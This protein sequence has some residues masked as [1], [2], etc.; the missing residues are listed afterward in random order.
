MSRAQRLG[1]EKK[2]TKNGALSFPFPTPGF[3]SE[4]RQSRKSGIRRAA[5]SS[6]HGRQT[7]RERKS[8]IV[9]VTQA[10]LDAV[11]RM[12]PLRNLSPRS[13]FALVFI[14]NFSF[15]GLCLRAHVLC[16]FFIRFSSNRFFLQHYS[17]NTTMCCVAWRVGGI[18][19]PREFRGVPFAEE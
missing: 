10:E 2:K 3:P 11:C 18:T 17:N 5:R 1:R 12:T 6:L 14:F 19:L 15:D 8:Q 7:F 9:P 16:S 4:E 13:L